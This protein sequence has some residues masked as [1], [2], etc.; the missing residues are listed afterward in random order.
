[1]QIFGSL[2][3]HLP[4]KENNKLVHITGVKGLPVFPLVLKFLV[5][6]FL[7]TKQNKNTAG[8]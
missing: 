1:M 7:K 3:F 6:C 4:T 8:Q 2:K 5:F